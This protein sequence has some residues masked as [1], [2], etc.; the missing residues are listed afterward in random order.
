FL[1]TLCRLLGVIRTN[2]EVILDRVR[3]AGHAFEQIGIVRRL[4]DARVIGAGGLLQN[5]GKPNMSETHFAQRTQCRVIDVVKLT[6]AIF[7]DRSIGLARFINIAKEPDEEL[8]N[9]HSWRTQAGAWARDCFSRRLKIDL[10]ILGNVFVADSSF[11]RS[12]V[13]SKKFS[14]AVVLCKILRV[15]RAFNPFCLAKLRT[16]KRDCEI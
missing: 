4:A 2:V 8:V 15:N 13:G 6:D 3:A 12:I 16:R 9:S 7:A 10:E 1:E 11:D 14:P 5:A